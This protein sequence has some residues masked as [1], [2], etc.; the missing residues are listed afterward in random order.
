MDPV[1]SRIAC[2]SSAD[3]SSASDSPATDDAF[4]YKGSTGTW[5]IR[6]VRRISI[7][8]ACDSGYRRIRMMCVRLDGAKIG[9]RGHSYGSCGFLDRRGF[10]ELCHT[11][12]VASSCRM[13]FCMSKGHPFTWRPSPHDDS[14]L[15]PSAIRVLKGSRVFVR[16]DRNG[17]ETTESLS[18]QTRVQN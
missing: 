6:C 14:A 2:R 16:V 8:S 15:V 10:S 4:E 18:S 1:V 12:G 17:E 13:T 7:G 11:S 5:R 3:S 9:R